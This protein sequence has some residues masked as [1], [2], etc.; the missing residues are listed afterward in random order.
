MGLSGFFLDTEILCTVNHTICVF[1][2]HGLRDNNQVRSLYCGEVAV[3]WMVHRKDLAELRLRL[4][5]RKALSRMDML[6]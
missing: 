1:Y 2:C 3:H 6:V 5:K 4:S